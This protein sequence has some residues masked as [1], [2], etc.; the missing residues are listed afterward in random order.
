VSISSGASLF[1]NTLLNF[2]FI[3]GGWSVWIDYDACSMANMFDTADNLVQ[4]HGDKAGKIHRAFFGMN[5]NGIGYL[6]YAKMAPILFPSEV[7][8]L[9]AVFFVEISSPYGL[10]FTYDLDNMRYI[11]PTIHLTPPEAGAVF[12]VSSFDQANFSPTNTTGPWAGAIF[13][14]SYFDSSYFGSKAVI[15]IPKRIGGTCRQV[16]FQVFTPGP[17]MP[18]KLHRFELNYKPGGR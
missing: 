4:V 13:D 9:E 3:R 7:T 12:D 1:E 6:S 5:D 17:N 15:R 2:D 18:W 10:D 16:E 14:L 8:L 11:S